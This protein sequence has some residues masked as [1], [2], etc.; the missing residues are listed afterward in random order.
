MK[1]LESITAETEILTANLK[2]IND[3]VAQNPDTDPNYYQIKVVFE[4]GD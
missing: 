3:W 1:N 4:N 2:R